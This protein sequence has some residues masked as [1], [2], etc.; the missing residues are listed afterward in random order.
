[1]KWERLDNEWNVPGCWSLKISLL[2]GL[3]RRSLVGYSPRGCK[4]KS[5]T[6]LSDFT[7]FFSFLFNHSV[8]SVENNADHT[9]GLW[10][11]LEILCC[12]WGFVYGT[13]SIHV[14]IVFITRFERQTYLLSVTLLG[15]EE[16]GVK[17][18]YKVYRFPGGAEVKAYQDI[19][20][21]QTIFLHMT[22]K[23]GMAG[24]GAGRTYSRLW[25]FRVSWK[26]CSLIW[27]LKCE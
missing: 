11:G 25:T 3:R 1:M 18:W 2:N 7:F 15:V 14:I 13:V 12:I 9:A 27:V 19:L 4:E 8:S 24:F 6:W 22:E 26:G 10:W 16:P 17:L 21:I 23:T 20:C 5:R